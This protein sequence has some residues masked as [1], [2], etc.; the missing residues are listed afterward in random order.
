MFGERGL[1]WKN[2]Y[3]AEQHGVIERGL[4]LILFYQT[5]RAPIRGFGFGKLTGSA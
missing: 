4:T 2:G 3:A 1:R 5:E